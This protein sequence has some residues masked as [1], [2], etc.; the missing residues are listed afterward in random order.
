MA[1]LGLTNSWL[2]SV[3]SSNHFLVNGLYSAQ[4]QHICKLN[5]K[6]QRMERK[7]I[8]CSGNRSKRTIGKVTSF[9]LGKGGV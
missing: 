5:D 9:K 3:A 2:R 7:K 8:K 4:T 1:E 6:R